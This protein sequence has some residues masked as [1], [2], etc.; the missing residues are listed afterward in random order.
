M[1]SA[2]QPRWPVLDGGPA[3]VTFTGARPWK[4]DGYRV[5]LAGRGAALDSVTAGVVVMESITHDAGDAI[6]LHAD[7]AESQRGRELHDRWATALELPLFVWERADAGQVSWSTPLAGGV[8]ERGPDG[9]RLAL[10]SPAPNVRIVFETET[11]AL[12]VDGDGRIHWDCGRQD[13]LVAVVAAGDDDF[14]RSLD[15]VARRTLAGLGRQRVQHAE[16]LQRGGTAMRSAGMPTLA[17]A[18]DWAKI[19]GD[20]LLGGMLADGAHSEDSTATPWLLAEAMLAAG[21]PHLPRALRRRETAAASAGHAD[22]AS[23]V[24]AWTG[25]AEQGADESVSPAPPPTGIERPIAPELRV[26]AAEE[27]ASGEL[28]ASGIA[29]FLAGAIGGLWGVRPQALDGMLWLA[30]DAMR[31]GSS[32][33]LSR[34]RVG[35]SV[36]DV[37]FRSSA[38]IVSLAV[39][40]GAGPA[41][42]TEISVRGVPIAE[43]LVDGEAVAG[44]RARFEVRDAHDVQF[45]LSR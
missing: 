32:A 30:P 22:W 14:E 10:H 17:D 35:R 24:S 16:Q 37:R 23:R 41:I 26:P 38:E 13:R 44:S 25:E 2:A 9:S 20:A 5:H 34:L 39:R 27:I 11:G 21:L 43:M 42:V 28:G 1:H 6:A 40:R 31:L 45:H 7:R 12:R 33:A 18:F 15:L 4:H 3:V 29:S 8:V 19:R 36:L